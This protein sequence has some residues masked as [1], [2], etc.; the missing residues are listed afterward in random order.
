MIHKTG[1]RDASH[2]SDPGG[3]AIRERKGFRARTARVWLHRLG[4]DWRQIRKG[5]Y[6]DGHERPDVLAERE[7]FLDMLDKLDPFLVRFDVEGNI[8]PQEYPPNCFPGSPISKPIILITHDESTFNTHDG[9]RY[10]WH[11]KDMPILQP[12]GRGKG[13][14]VSDFLLPSSRLSA[15]TLSASARLELRIPEFATKLFEFGTGSE[16]YWG[17][18]EIVQ[19]VT[20]T[21]IP[22][23][24]AIYP[25]YQA[26][27]LFDN[28]TSHSAFAE[29]ALRVQH[30]NLDPGGKQS[31]MRAGYING[32]VTNVQLMI[33]ENGEP[34][35]IRQ[36]LQERNLWHKDLRLECSKPL[37][38]PCGGRK[39][40]KVCIAGKVCDTCLI[41]RK[42]PCPEPCMR[43]RKCSACL[44]RRA[45]KTCRKRVLCVS[46]EP[47][48]GK[49]CTDCE[50]LPPA[51]TT[52]GK[53]SFS[54]IQLLLSY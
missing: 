10:A 20:E 45:C 38:G 50:E 44:A 25:G 1:I 9:R 16:G 24:K 3:K 19:Q 52:Y 41:S 54:E 6:F 42:A 2:E 11:T 39:K 33:N 27:F 15:S 28:A 46:C 34:K 32:D 37:C 53:Q 7:R 40:C 14:M 30:M 48:H 35:G 29:D 47:F 17:G 31:K 22:I 21:V 5:V 51:C 43:T 8:L 13:I 4:L 18:D 36:V 49:K 23:F 12:K 26:L